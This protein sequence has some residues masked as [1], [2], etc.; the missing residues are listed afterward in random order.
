MR[1]EELY[2]VHEELPGDDEEHN[3]LRLVDGADLCR[4]LLPEE[5]GNESI[6]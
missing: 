3:R 4:T 6:E 5:D 1:V 2:R